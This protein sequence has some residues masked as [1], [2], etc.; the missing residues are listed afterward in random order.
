MDL[1]HYGS[2]FWIKIVLENTYYLSTLSASLVSLTLARDAMCM[3][4]SSFFLFL[5]ITSVTCYKIS[6][7]IHPSLAWFLEENGQPC[8]C[9][10]RW[11]EM[12]WGGSTRQY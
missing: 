6:F 12:K 11:D 7:H 1:K 3:V 9:I 5:S 10:D 2:S 8:P 4:Q